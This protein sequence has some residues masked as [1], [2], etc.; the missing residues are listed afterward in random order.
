MHIINIYH[1][2]A[3]TNTQNDQ[4]GKPNLENNLENNNTNFNISLFKKKIR[5]YSQLA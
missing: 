5:K 4:L 3:T 1:V 2:S